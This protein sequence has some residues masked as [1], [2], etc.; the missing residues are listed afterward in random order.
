MVFLG[1]TKDISAKL[2]S[3]S[4]EKCNA[5]A[6]CISVLL[7][8]R[9]D[10]DTVVAP[11]A[12]LASLMH[13]L[14]HAASVIPLGRQHLVHTQYHAS[15]SIDNAALRRSESSRS[16]SVERAQMVAIHA[17]FRLCPSRCAT[18]IPRDFP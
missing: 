16:R 10:R 17:S 14:L 9:W 13:K 3:L 4:P 18:G 2:L 1:V 11:A 7:D 5:Y 15:I 12:E 8:G 6:A